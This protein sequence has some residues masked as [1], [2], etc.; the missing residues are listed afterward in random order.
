M[1][2]TSSLRVTKKD[3]LAGLLASVV[4]SLADGF[5]IPGL[6]ALA[7]RVLVDVVL[8]SRVDRIA[9]FLEQLHSRLQLLEESQL[10][11]VVS[12]DPKMRNLLEQGLVV[13]VQSLSDDKVG[14]AASV[15]ATGL[16][17]PDVD[18]VNCIEL[19]SIVHRLTD[20]EVRVLKSKWESR[21]RDRYQQRLGVARKPSTRANAI[22]QRSASV[23][24]RQSEALR[25]QAVLG[26]TKTNLL[27]Q[28]FHRGPRDGEPPLSSETG[29]VCSVGTSLTYLGG[30]VCEILWRTTDEAGD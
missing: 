6:G 9:V 13:A 17:D 22:I 11:K 26:L 1:N 8:P 28:V 2:D 7:E 29:M 30:M 5:T 4:G 16:S 15:V 18:V 3:Q 24:E 12:S 10:A 20:M 25:E 23:R 14:H 27:K 19:L 21:D